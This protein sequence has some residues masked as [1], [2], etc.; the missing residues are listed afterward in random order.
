MKCAAA[1]AGHGFRGVL[2]LVG[3]TSEPQSANVRSGIDVLGT[4]PGAED[5]I[6]CSLRWQANRGRGGNG[7]GSEAQ[8]VGYTSN[9]SRLRCCNGNELTRRKRRFMLTIHEHCIYPTSRKRQQL[10]STMSWNE[11]WRDHG[12]ATR[13][14]QQNGGTKRVGRGIYIQNR[15]E[16]QREA[17]RC[18]PQLIC[19]RFNGYIGLRRYA[20]EW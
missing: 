20:Y 7:A 18:G 11:C 14:Q 3:R 12:G 6:A 1:L 13:L 19:P 17:W 4:E 5:K 8:D 9:N 15:I 2:R 16:W 10:R